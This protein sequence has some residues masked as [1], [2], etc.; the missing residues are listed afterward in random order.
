MTGSIQNTSNERIAAIGR[1]LAHPQFYDGDM[2]A[3]IRWL[4]RENELLRNHCRHQKADGDSLETPIMKAERER[5][6]AR[7]QFDR[8]VEWAA[9]HCDCTHDG[10]GSLTH[11]CQEHEA[12][13]KERDN[14]LAVLNGLLGLVQLADSRDDMPLVL[15]DN[16][17]YKDA[18][19]LVNGIEAQNT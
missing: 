3:D 4:L 5:D 12:I 2:G 11:E 6:E 1:A 18:L 13:R 8:H 14:L 10:R 16:H 17:R 19:S 15:A 9:D 7:A